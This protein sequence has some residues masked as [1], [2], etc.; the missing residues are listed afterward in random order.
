MS[1]SFHYLALGS[2]INTR[3]YITA[4]V[5]QWASV[6][7]QLYLG[8]L[9]S[10]QPE[11]VMLDSGWPNQ[12]EIESRFVNACFAVPVP[13]DLIDAHW[14]LGF[15][16]LLEI[17]FDRPLDLPDRRR[18]SRTIDIDY[19]GSDPTHLTELLATPNHYSCLGLQ[20]LVQQ[21]L[22]EHFGQHPSSRETPYER[23]THIR[24]TDFTQSER[25]QFIW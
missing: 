21:T 1:N 20:A 11:D 2:N 4:V 9:F 7:G 14:C 25:I 12:D 23:A 18:V 24:K 5:D 13:S 6:F 8:P 15:S 17:A 10:T 16:K 22:P 3:H 19:L